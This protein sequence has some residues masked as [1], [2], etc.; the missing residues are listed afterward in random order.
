MRRGYGGGRG[1]EGGRCEEE[2]VGIVGGGGRGGIR[3][4]KERER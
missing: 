1:S 2:G 4:P 3:G